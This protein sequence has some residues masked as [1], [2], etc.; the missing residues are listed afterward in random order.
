MSFGREV[1]RRRTALRLTLEQLAER[2]D[3][4]PHF[5]S[6]VETGKRDPSLSTITAI[7]RG[8]GCVAGE[9]LGGIRD[10]TPAGHE[11]GRLLDAA[12]PDVQEGVLRILRAT[13]RRRR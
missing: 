13:A 6:T 10:L 11:A 4:S 7:A 12:P 1:R 2:A 3:L 9:L 8:L 5:L